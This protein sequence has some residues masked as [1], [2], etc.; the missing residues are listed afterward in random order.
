MK[1]MLDNWTFHWTLNIL[2]HM[3]EHIPLYVVLQAKPGVQTW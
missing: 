3:Q 2:D 1:K